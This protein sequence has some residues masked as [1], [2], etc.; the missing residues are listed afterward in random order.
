MQTATQQNCREEARSSRGH[1]NK[2]RSAGRVGQQ[3][4]PSSMRKLRPRGRAAVYKQPT[5]KTTRGD[6]VRHDQGGHSQEKSH[7]LSR[8]RR[9]APTSSTK[10][11]SDRRTDD[12]HG[13]Q[14]AV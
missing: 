14:T 3:D 9:Y 2:G 11:P 7:R 1:A 10:E 6:L 4:L 13:P 12:R 5:T 8:K